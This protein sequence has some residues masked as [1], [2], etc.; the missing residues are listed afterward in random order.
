[1]ADDGRRAEAQFPTALYP[2]NL[3]LRSEMPI[4]GAGI[5]TPKL[6]GRERKRVEKG[7]FS[8][9]VRMDLI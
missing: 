8:Y 4:L 2:F 6:G 3:V 9:S 5:W 7:C 1:M